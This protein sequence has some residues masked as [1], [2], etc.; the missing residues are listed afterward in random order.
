[1]SHL[2][3]GRFDSPM[4]V[5]LHRCGWIRVIVNSSS[6]SPASTRIYRS[7]VA[8]RLWPSRPS[9][10]SIS[11][12]GPR[13]GVVA[14]SH[15]YSGDMFKSAIKYQI[16]VYFKFIASAKLKRSPTTTRVSRMQIFWFQGTQGQGQSVACTSHK[17]SS[18]F[19]R[20]MW[21]DLI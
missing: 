14:F 1:M 7:E 11:K 6:G 12:Q 19:W 17:V 13:T 2:G 8:K 10:Q 16:L 18:C 21:G 4:L 15:Y 20:P 3:C 5:G 9:A